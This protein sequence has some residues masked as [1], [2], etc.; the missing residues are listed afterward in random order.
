MAR[1]SR[2]AGIKPSTKIAGLALFVLV[3][4]GAYTIGWYWLADQLRARTESLIAG[5]EA[6]GVE[7]A[8]DDLAVRGYP[9]RLGVF[10]AGVSGQGAAGERL[11]AGAFRSAAQIY[12][13]SHIVSE[14]DG[15]LTIETDDLTATGDWQ[16]LGLSTVFDDMGLVR[17]ALEGLSVSA[18]LAADGAPQTRVS[19]DRIAFHARRNGP[20]LDLAF[21][22]DALTAASD[23][24][25]ANLPALSL[26]MIATLAEG[27]PYLAGEPFASDSL[28][29]EAGTLQDLTAT[30]AGGGALSVSGPFE[31]DAEGR[32]S[33][34][35]A[36][37]ASDLDR[38]IDTAKEAVPEAAG[39]IE[40]ASGI[41]ASLAGGDGDLSVDI[42]VED[43]RARLGFIPIGD[44]PPI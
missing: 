25:P 4:I 13:P 35:F 1:S 22:A 33:G 5:L 17:S 31:I 40:T 12:R 15:P 32:I 24:I 43:G 30:L 44:I 7:A 23:V 2:K 11:A 19:A 3:A 29:G 8:C 39:A 34:D 38:L 6:D 14:L 16:T 28:R 27:A 36:V 26:S 42:T 10:C 37:S 41:I 18:D 20:A 21:S 9:F